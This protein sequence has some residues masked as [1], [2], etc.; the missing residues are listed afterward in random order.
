MATLDP[1]AVRQ[2]TDAVAS[3]PRGAEGPVF[4]EPWEAQAFAMAV[5]LHQRGLFAWSEWAATLADEIKRAQGAGDPDTGETYYRHWLAA[6]ERVV[7]AKGVCDGATLAR[8]RDAWDHAADRTPHGSPIEL[9]P[10]DFDT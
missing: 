2:A 6:L 9:T 7:A 4:R 5:A 8:Y 10:Q 3:I 1:T